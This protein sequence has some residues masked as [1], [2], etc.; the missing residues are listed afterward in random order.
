MFLGS[1]CLVTSVSHQFWHFQAELEFW[2]AGLVPWLGAA[3]AAVLVLDW[4]RLGWFG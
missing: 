2:F 1:F 3:G 4:V